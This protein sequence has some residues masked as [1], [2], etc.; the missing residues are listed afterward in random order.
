[1]KYYK[2]IANTPYCNTQNEYYHSFSDDI[3]EKEL[4]EIAEEY[5]LENGETYSY[6]ATGWEDDFE[7]EE[8][9]EMYY[10]DCECCYYEILEEEFRENAE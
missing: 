9:K 8:D 6:L 3:S 1:M 4:N 10:D 7:T 2:F 5:R